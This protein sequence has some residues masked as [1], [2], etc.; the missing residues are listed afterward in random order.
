MTKELQDKLLALIE[1]WQKLAEYEGTR[2]WVAEGLLIAA[3]DLRELL[4]NE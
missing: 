2:T 3:N 1:T 4:V